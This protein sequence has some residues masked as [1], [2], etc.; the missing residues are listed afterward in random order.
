MAGGGEVD[1]EQFARSAQRFAVVGEV[2]LDRRSGNLDRQAAV[3]AAILDAL[4]GEPVLL[5]VHSAG[6]SSEVVELIR[7]SRR[8]G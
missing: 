1:V 8:L 5:S 2:G 7:R 3:F 4:R 6:C